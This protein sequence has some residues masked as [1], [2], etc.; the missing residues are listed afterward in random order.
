MA[1]VARDFPHGVEVLVPAG[2]LGNRLNAMH[3]FHWARGIQVRLRTSKHHG[4]DY[5]CW[6]FADRATANAFA[7]EFFVMTSSAAPRRK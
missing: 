2:G 1:S 6:C 5:L 4:H 3:E 7:A